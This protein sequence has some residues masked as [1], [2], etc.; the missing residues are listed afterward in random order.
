MVWKQTLSW[1]VVIGI[2]IETSLGSR[3]STLE[4]WNFD[5]LPLSVFL[6]NCGIDR[7]TGTISTK[8]PCG[9]WYTVSAVW[10]LIRRIYYW[11]QFGLSHPNCLKTRSWTD[12]V[13]VISSSLT[14]I[15]YYV[16]ILP[17]K[18]HKSSMLYLVWFKMWYSACNIKKLCYKSII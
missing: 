4:P 8:T 13:F 14:V 16:H 11:A 17:G 5:P 18:M 6:H 3:T 9:F 12:Y 10:F 2:S 15:L 1:K 7:A